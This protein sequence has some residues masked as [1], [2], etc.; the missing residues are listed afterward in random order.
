MGLLMKIVSHLRNSSDSVSQSEKQIS[1]SI[2]FFFSS[3]EMSE[4][5]SASVVE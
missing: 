1:Q 4:F 5:S 2:S 3:L